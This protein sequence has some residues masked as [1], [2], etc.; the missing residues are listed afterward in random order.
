MGSMNTKR[1]VVRLVLEGK[2]PPYV[3]WSMGFTKEAKEKLQEHYG[4]DDTEGPLENHLLKLGSDIGFFTDLGN[5]RVQDAFGVVWDR[6][7]DKDIGNVEGCVLAEP[8]LGGYEFPDPL[9]QRFFEDIPEKIE[10]F[11]DR[12]RVFQI[13]FSLY[14]RAWTLRGMENLLMD[15][16]DHADFVRALFAAIAVWLTIVSFVSVMRVRIREQPAIVVPIC[17]FQREDWRQ[18]PGPPTGPLQ[19]GYR[20]TIPTHSDAPKGFLDAGRIRLLALSLP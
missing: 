5:N 9:D 8:S 14:E 4:C 3:P 7:V 15:F 18:A 16:Y 12:F 17:V 10:R 20:G 19:D 11:P 6:S 2:R 13:G 1:E